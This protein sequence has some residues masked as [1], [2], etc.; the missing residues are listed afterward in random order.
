MSFLWPVLNPDNQKAS[1]AGV[2]IRRGSAHA[3]GAR[4][5]GRNNTPPDALPSRTA[6]SPDRS[7]PRF[8]AVHHQRRGSAV[9]SSPPT[10]ITHTTVDWHTRTLT[11]GAARGIG[12]L[13]GKYC[14]CCRSKLPRAWS[15]NRSVLI[16]RCTAMRS[17]LRV[18][19]VRAGFG[20]DAAGAHR[21]V[22]VAAGVVLHDFLLRLRLHRQRLT[23]RSSS[24]AQRC[25]AVTRVRTSASSSDSRRSR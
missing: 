1:G 14:A 12:L 24:R 19:V 3:D 21:A 2:E 16:E 8:C 20:R 18:L 13:P 10:T 11:P 22:L 15:V 17:V 6:E 25:V 4:E 7:R 23:G 5:A 9:P